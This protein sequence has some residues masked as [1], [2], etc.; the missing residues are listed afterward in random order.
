M[1]RASRDYGATWKQRLGEQED[2]RRRCTADKDGCRNG[3]LLIYH[4]VDEDDVYRLGIAILCLDDLSE[5]LFRY[6]EPILEPGRYYER[7]GAA[8]V[9]LRISTTYTTAERIESFA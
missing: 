9:K 2:N 3:W 5:V 1:V 7:Q 4:G 8:P 6:P